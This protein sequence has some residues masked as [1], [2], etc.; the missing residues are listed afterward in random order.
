MAKNTSLSNSFLNLSRILYITLSLQCFIDIGPNVLIS[1]GIWLLAEFF[2]NGE[3]LSHVIRYRQYSYL[4][5]FLVY[6]L[7]ALF[8][9]GSSSVINNIAA[10]LEVVSPL[11][12]YDLCVK[13]N[14]KSSKE[15]IICYTVVCV[16][17]CFYSYYFLDVYGLSSM[18]KFMSVENLFEDSFLLRNSFKFTSGLSLIVP[19]YVYLYFQN[20]W[21][22]RPKLKI[23]LLFLIVLF[24]YTVFKAQFV[25]AIL[26][27]FLGSLMAL[28]YKNKMWFFIGGLTVIIVILILP[29]IIGALNNGSR[30]NT[31][32]VNRLE[33]INSTIWGQGRDTED[34]NTRSELSSN[35]FNTFI[36]N[37]I[38]GVSLT[39]S[40]NLTYNDVGNHASWVDLLA[41]YGLFALLLFITMYLHIK[42]QMKV[43]YLSLVPLLF[44]ILGFL[45]PLWFFQ[46]MSVAFLYS[47]LLLKEAAKLRS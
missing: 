29:S 2:F 33:E 42:K 19:V 8:I 31:V 35:S 44:V 14:N 41:K 9:S 21:K 37:P 1:W 18:R 20:K 46:V 13:E 7:I 22:E 30:N 17:N 40:S 39:K 47:P 43:Y 45:N 27:M 16:L 3:H 15:L 28:G 25:T 26:I 6:L 34:L 11:L 23:T 12:M 10:F 38:F 32:V 36:N 4:L 5:L 24:A